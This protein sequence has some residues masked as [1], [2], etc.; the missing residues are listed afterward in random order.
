MVAMR[1][2]TARSLAVTL[3]A[4]ALASSGALHA[5]DFVE[6]PALSSGTSGLLDLL[7]VAVPAEVKGLTFAAPGGRTNH[8]VGWIYQICPRANATPKNE[9]PAGSG[10]FAE[11]GGVR[12]ALRKGDELKIRLVNRL[13]KIDA[14]RLAHAGDSG[15]GNLPLNLT[16]LHTHGLVVPA[17]PASPNDP[18]WGDYIFMQIYNSGNGAPISQGHHDHGPMIKDYADYRIDVPANHPSG[19]FWFHPHVHGIALNQVSSGLSG[20]ISI[21]AVGDYAR[22]DRSKAAFPEDHVRHLVL[23]DMQV[24]AAGDI[25]IHKKTVHFQDGEV[26]T[27]QDSTFCDQHPSQATDTRLGS[28]PGTNNS[29]GNSFAGGQ[30]YFTVSGQ[31]YPTIRVREADGEVWQLTNASGSISYLL[32]LNNDAT[33]QPMRMQLISVDGISVSI[34][35]N[36]A[37]GTLFELGGARFRFADCPLQPGASYEST[38]VCVDQFTMMPSSRVGLWVTYRNAQGQPVPAPQNATATFK[39]VGL[40]TGLAGDL[41]PEINL[42]HVEFSP[43]GSPQL[44]ESAL[45]LHGEALTAN[46]VSGLLAMPNPLAKPAPLPT[47]CTPLPAGHHRRIFFG[48]A[49]TQNPDSFGLGYEELDGDQKIVA[50]RPVTSFNPSDTTICLPLGPRQ[51]TVHETWELVNLATEMHNFHIHQTKFRVI[52]KSDSRFSEVLDP[53]VGAGIMEDN[54]PLLS[55]TANIPDVANNQNGYCTMAQWHN[56]QCSSSP[57]LADIPFSQLG[58]FVFHC[59]ILEHE[60]GGM[61]ARIRVV[62]SAQ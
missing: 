25:Q 23:K 21:G 59:H 32:Q 38:P 43:S 29:G 33:G 42:A 13:P 11:Y 18:T 26:L 47:A 54:V 60:D 45:D 36:T 57:V 34:P 24:L 7:M 5:S 37:K 51:S 55:A 10:T 9:C 40:S 39:S 1:A 2:V 53:H 4:A 50:Q 8:P 19:A 28:C 35:P 16:N 44:A 30:W 56:Q 22:G 52:Q 62:P 14:D 6:P 61:M 3:V 41:W 27:Q 12:L 48:L 20:I 58:T 31:Q 17:R 49:D 46:L 15:G